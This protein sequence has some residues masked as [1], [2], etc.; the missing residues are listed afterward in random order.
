MKK[1]IRKHIKEK[2]FVKVYL[3]DD[4]G[5]N[6]THF[7]GIIFDQN[8]EHILM[9][10]LE[11]FNYD[12]FVVAKKSDISEIKR[13]ANELFFDSIISREGIKQMIIQ[14]AADLNFKLGVF[15]DMFNSLKKIGTAIIIENLYGSDSI[16]Q[17]GPINKVGKKRVYIDYFSANGEY[18][19]KPASSKYENITF[20]KFDCPY[21]NQYFKYSKKIV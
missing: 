8:K 12:G 13:T 5:I 11:D 6:L 17:I 21:A 3:V 9:C 15:P 10:D 1:R 4:K 14:K 16:F 20:F 7:T 2:N 18:D 19:L